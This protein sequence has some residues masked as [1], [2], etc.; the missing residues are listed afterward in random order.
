MSLEG[1][2]YGV[3]GIGRFPVEPGGHALPT[4]LVG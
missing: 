3:R 4:A 1:A 2:G